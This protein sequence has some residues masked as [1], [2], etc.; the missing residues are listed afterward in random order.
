MVIGSYRS[1]WKRCLRVAYPGREQ[2]SRPGKVLRCH[3]SG[4]ALRLRSVAWKGHLPDSGED[5]LRQKEEID[6]SDK[7]DGCSARQGEAG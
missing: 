5:E 3:S 1:V 7:V 2:N 6:G 4:D